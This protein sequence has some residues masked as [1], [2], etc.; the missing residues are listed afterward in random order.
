MILV[1]SALRESIPVRAGRTSAKGGGVPP[2]Y[3]PLTAFSPY[4]CSHPMRFTIN[5]AR[6]RSVFYTS[7]KPRRTAGTAAVH[8]G[9]SYVAGKAL[10]SPEVEEEKAVEEDSSRSR[11]WRFVRRERRSE[12]NQRHEG[13]L[14]PSCS[15]RAVVE[16]LIG[17]SEG[18]VA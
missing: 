1:S 10:R 17:E 15:R 7:P 8:S 3:G 16:K 9:Q 4:P 11:Y 18:S 5:T 13:S 6:G 2:A 12:L 14:S